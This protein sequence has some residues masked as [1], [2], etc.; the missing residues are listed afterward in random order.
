MKALTVVPG[1]NDPLVLRDVA[2]PDEAE[3]Q[4]MVQTLAVGL[5]G[6]DTEITSGGYGQAPAGSPCLILG[7]ENLGRVLTAPAGSGLSPGDLVVCIV[8][9]PDPVPCAAC[10]AGQW[11]MCRNGRYTEHGI[12]G[13]QG[14]ARERY[15]ADPD[16]LVR[17]PNTLADVG[18]LLEP[19]TIVAKAW[20]HID[21]IGS[22]AFFAPKTAVVTG[23]GPVGLLAALLGVQRGLDVHVFDQ[24]RAGPIPGLVRDLGATYHPESLTESGIQADILVECTGVASVVLETLTCRAPDSVTCLTGVSSSG[25]TEPVDLGALNRALV[26]GNESVFGS[27]NANRSHYE[28]AVQAL[29]QADSAWLQR[30]ITRRVPLADFQDASRRQETDVKVVLEVKAG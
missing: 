27:V 9:R 13:L 29:E 30:L 3:G 19:T 28:A 6:T 21:A 20:Q 25:R 24:V 14:F 2:E 15:R 18:V 4:V 23:A 16:A 11:D 22:R 7:H 12:K 1:T 17:L 8:R 26:L 10:A 5:C